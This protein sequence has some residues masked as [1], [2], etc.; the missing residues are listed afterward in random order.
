MNYN[1]YLTQK[2]RQ[3]ARYYVQ[4]QKKLLVYMHGTFSHHHV[5]LDQATDAET[6]TLGLMVKIFPRRV[7]V[8]FRH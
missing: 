3:L 6:S 2:A 4:L 8:F 1:R 7:H 5:K